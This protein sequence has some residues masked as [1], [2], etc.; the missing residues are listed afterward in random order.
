MLEELCHRTKTKSKCKLCL[1]VAGSSSMTQQRG[2]GRV[3][4]SSITASVMCGE[5]R[6]ISEISMNRVANNM[7]FLQP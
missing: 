3:K 4:T 1:L 2:G 5:E 7:E 6:I